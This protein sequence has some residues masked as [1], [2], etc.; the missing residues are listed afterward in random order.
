MNIYYIIHKIKL[1][2]MYN[3]TYVIIINDLLC[4][5]QSINECSVLVSRYYLLCIYYICMTM[6]TASLV[7]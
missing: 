4:N 3:I 5:T 6:G 2:I 1:N 7:L